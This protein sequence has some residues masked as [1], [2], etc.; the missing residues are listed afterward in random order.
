MIR[1]PT[2]VVMGERDVVFPPAIVID[3]MRQYL[4]EAGNTR[5]TTRI[6]PGASHGMLEVQT[7]RGRRFRGTISREFLGTLTDWV[8]RTTSP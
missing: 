2:L 8:V 3:R 6:I 5:V 7:W 1:V 4:G